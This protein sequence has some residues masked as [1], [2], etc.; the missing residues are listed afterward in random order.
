MAKKS[1]A[2]R[3]A[4][5]LFKI[6]VDNKCEKI[7]L[8]DLHQVG[9]LLKEEGLMF[10]LDSPKF[11]LSEKISLLDEVFENNIN[12]F[13]LKLL[14]LLADNKDFKYFF[15]IYNSYKLIVYDS[16]K[17][18][19]GELVTAVNIEQSSINNIK[20]KLEN[21][22]DKKIELTTSI[23]SELI[24]GF[25]AKVGDK[26]LDASARSYLMK[27]KKEIKD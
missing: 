22:L 7:L 1:P 4:Q 10:L 11:K 27:M 15:S 14:Y 23:N 19:I 18:E 2:R 16:L 17:I 8:D 21:N 20:E 9:E 3:Y 26:V 13:S 5:A 12:Q 25:V 6:G 24:A